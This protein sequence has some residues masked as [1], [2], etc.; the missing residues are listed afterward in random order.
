MLNFGPDWSYS[1]YEPGY[2]LV[3]GHNFH[4]PWNETK[5][6]QEEETSM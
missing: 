4:A 6:L 1:Q 3:A 5:Q 2:I